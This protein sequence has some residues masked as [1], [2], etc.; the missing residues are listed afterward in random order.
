MKQLYI[1]DAKYN[2]KTITTYEKISDITGATKNTLASLKCKGKKLTRLKD[3]Y[4]I[5][6]NT[7]ITQLRKWYE[8]VKFENEVWKTI[9]GSDQIFKI[10]NYGR[11]KR[12]YKKCPEGKFI[13]PYFITRRKNANKNKQFIKVKFLGEYKEYSVSRL[14]AYHFVDIYYDSDGWTKKGKALKYKNYTFDD[15]VVFH[16]NGL[17]YDNF[18]GNLEFLDREDLGKKTA[19]KSR[20]GKTIIAID[21]ITNEIVD[22]FKST[23]HAESKLPVSK[24]SVSDSLNK[25]YKTNIVGG[26]YKFEYEK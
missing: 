17:V 14:V 19:Y 4:L 26:R 6:E 20:G 12:I 22:Y 3:C 16:K 25:V 10:S 21:V 7:N 8:D 23:R 2:L 5:D 13:L 18:H 11:F 1:Y 9:E 24:Q 15:V